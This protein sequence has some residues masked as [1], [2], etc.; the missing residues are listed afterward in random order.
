MVWTKFVLRFHVEGSKKGSSP[1]LAEGE[2]LERARGKGAGTEAGVRAGPEPRGGGR[3]GP[4]AVLPSVFRAGTCAPRFRAGRST[5]PRRN[6][7][8][9]E[10][11][12][13]AVP[14]TSFPRPR[15]RSGRCGYGTERARGGARN[16]SRR[17]SPTSVVRFPASVIWPVCV[18]LC[19]SGEKEVP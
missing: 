7:R 3:R 13:R 1:E 11:R 17:A 19:A 15:P 4:V 12:S 16:Q 2:G 14:F 6:P 8:F 9:G 18:L 10:M 5:Q